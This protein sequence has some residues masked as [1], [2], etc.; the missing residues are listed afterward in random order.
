M[1]LWWIYFDHAKGFARQRG[2]LVYQSA[3][4]IMSNPVCVWNGVGACSFCSYRCIV[5]FRN[6]CGGLVQND[7][8]ITVIFSSDKESTPEIQTESNSLSEISFDS[9]SLVFTQP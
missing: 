3:G 6:S 1:L 4:N 9:K 2:A 7:Y 8:I 5:K